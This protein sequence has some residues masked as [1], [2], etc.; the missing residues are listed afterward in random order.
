M[1]SALGLRTSVA[2]AP[3]TVKIL[4]MSL[5]WRCNRPNPCMTSRIVYQYSNLMMTPLNL[6]QQYQSII[7]DVN[8]V[9]R[10]RARNSVTFECSHLLV[11]FP[12][13][14]VYTTARVLASQAEAIVVR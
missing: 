9:K 4:A 1:H 8:D 3:P 6:L 13:Y 12:R 5:A 7:F 11:T 10:L 2:L 14:D